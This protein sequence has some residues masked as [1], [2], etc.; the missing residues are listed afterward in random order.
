MSAYRYT[1]NYTSGDMVFDFIDEIIYC[2]DTITVLDMQGLTNGCREAEDSWVGIEFPSICEAEGKTDLDQLT[3]VQ[4][5]ITLKLLGDWRI[6]SEKTSGKFVATAGNLVQG[7]PNL[8]GDPF[9]PNPLV[10]YISIQSAASTIVSVSSGS[11]LSTEE[12]NR[13]MAIPTVTLTPE[14]DAKLTAIPEDT[15]EA[16]ERAQLMGISTDELLTEQ[17]AKELL[18]NRNN[19]ISNR[20]IVQY[21]AGGDTTVNVTYDADGIPSSEQMQ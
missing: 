9:E 8:G 11:G 5:G 18:I 3:G 14:Q 7:G 17:R 10:N 12:H 19:T 6:Y 2:E 20:R 21:V 16:D 1:Y 4:V 15:L 13:L